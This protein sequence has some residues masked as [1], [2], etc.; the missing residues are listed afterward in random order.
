MPGQRQ[1]Q[2]KPKHPKEKRPATPTFLL[3]LP[4]VVDPGQATRLRAHLEA[5]RQLYNAILSQGQKC[6]R[7]MRSDAAW[8]AAR[9]LPRTQKTQRAVA[10]SALRKQYGFTEAAL[11]EA[12]KSLRVGWIAE[13]I[14]AVLA[15]TLATRAYRALNRV[16][17]GQ[18]KRVRFKSRGRGFSSIENKRNDTG[19]RFV[20]RPPE[21][22][23]AGFLLWNGDQLPAFIDWKDEVVTHGLR[24]RI[25]YA[26]LV[27]RPAS[28]PKA[29]GAD[30]EGYRYV[31]QLALEGTPHRKPKHTVG[32]GVI[33]AD[34]GPST[35]ALVPQEGEASLVV[36]CAQLAPDA[37]AIRRLQRRMDRQR[38]AGNPENY[39]EK[40][41]IKKQGHRKL[42][43][44]Q[45]KRYQATRRRKAA[46]ERKLAAHRKSLHGRKMHEV[47]ALGST[48]IIEKV[49]Y[50]AW[51]RRFGKSVGLRAPGMFVELLRR[52]VASTGGTLVEVPTRTTALSQ[53]CHGCGKK[54]KKSL[55]QRWHQCECG[56][57]PV[58]RDLYSAFL[59]AYLDPAH[60]LP[61]CA[62]YQPYWEGA[63]ARLR[64]AHERTTQR[65]REGQA[66]P[67]SLGVTRAR[68]RLP[69]SPGEPPLEPA[70]LLWREEREAWAELLEPP[71]L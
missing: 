60:P 34:L 14:D 7:R 24:H 53:W 28:S 13:H 47:L 22:G 37:R 35:L 46:K 45:S 61:S 26:R 27:Q 56:I 65:A 30:A 2:Q 16:C 20:L 63:E 17:L 1:R 52:T 41:R 4:L 55:S 32:Q 23:N 64:A 58:Q 3:E 29:A 39:D 40:G 12:V 11:H 67:R 25:K 70:L 54:V 68:A 48:I 21:K 49:S 44:K 18:A 33:G 31:V 59:A 43:W 10:F 50:K 38:R 42:R 15:Q 66:L 69:E 9:D 19:L 71:L 8:Q 5:A 62:R 57:G 51:Q 6:L 36:F